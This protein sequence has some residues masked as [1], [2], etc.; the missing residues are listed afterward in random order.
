LAQA[1]RVIHKNRP[2]DRGVLFKHPTL[3]YIWADSGYQG[4][5]IEDIK[6]EAGLRGEVVQSASSSRHRLTGK[7]LG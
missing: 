6:R 3:E 2:V 4:G 7:T 1:K 5:G